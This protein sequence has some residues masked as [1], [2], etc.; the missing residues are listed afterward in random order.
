M[1]DY[2][3]ICLQKSFEPHIGE[4]L[5]ARQARQGDFT[6]LDAPGSIDRILRE[7]AKGALGTL[8]RTEV[9]ALLEQLMEKNWSS[10]RRKLTS[11]EAFLWPL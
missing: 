3:L 8:S 5:F 10:G 2:H 4:W 1:V 11:S 9:E 7:L 6:T